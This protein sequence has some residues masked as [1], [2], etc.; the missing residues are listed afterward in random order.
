M[1]RP[2]SEVGTAVIT[3]AASGIGAAA[4]DAL[5]ERGWIVHGA[6]RTPIPC[7]AGCAS[8][9]VDVTDER[10][11][12]RLAQ[13][14][15]PVDA[16]V[17]AA[18]VLIRPGDGPTATLDLTAWERTLAVNLTG[19]MLTVRA[20]VGQ[21][22]DGGAVVTVGSVAGISAMVGLDA[23]TASKGAVVALTRS[24]AV[25]YSRRGIRVN[26]VCPGPTD[27]AMMQ[28]V[29]ADTEPQRRLDLP[30]QRMAE[31]AE[32]AAVIAFLASS[33]ASYLSGA[34]VPV[35]GAATANTAGMPFPRRRNSNEA[36]GQ[37]S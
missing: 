24:W 35:D 19:T 21:I 26:C 34:I 28:R 29:F 37:S 32:V 16:L 23:Y 18:G 6:D 14:V 30:Q 7:A 11:L 27:T 9:V 8:H 1:S 22:S 15:G 31:P 3:G 4:A 2:N 5:L 36:R 17:T 10:A 33:E 25:D 12:V 13:T 20:F